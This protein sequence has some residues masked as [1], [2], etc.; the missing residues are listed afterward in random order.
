M[1]F[2]LCTGGAASP[3][4]AFGVFSERLGIWEEHLKHRMDVY[5]LAVLAAG[6]GR[7]TLKEHLEF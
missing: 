5:K 4:A 1:M 2:F 7:S 3:K 6:L